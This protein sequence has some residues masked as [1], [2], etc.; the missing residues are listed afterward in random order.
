MFALLGDPL[1][2]LLL[3]YRT[4]KKTAIEYLLVIQM[5]WL[6]EAGRLKATLQANRQRL[7]FRI[8]HLSYFT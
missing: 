3:Y 6:I 1:N 7:L 8:L 5:L 4:Y 2:I